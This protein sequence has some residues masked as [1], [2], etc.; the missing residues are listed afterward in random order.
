LND[1]TLGTSENPFRNVNDSLGANRDR[2]P[3]EREGEFAVN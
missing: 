3:P 1:Q 2:V